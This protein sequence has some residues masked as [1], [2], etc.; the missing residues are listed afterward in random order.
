MVKTMELSVESL[1]G[2]ANQETTK[3][4]KQVHKLHVSVSVLLLFGLMHL[5]SYVL[6]GGGGPDRT[7]LI[8]S[9]S[10]WS[11]IALTKAGIY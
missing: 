10:T 7:C 1:L 8:I 11:P 3:T 6:W 4:V 5:V 2:R 9:A